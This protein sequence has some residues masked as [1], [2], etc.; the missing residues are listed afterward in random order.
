MRYVALLWGPVRD[1]RADVSA[2]TEAGGTM[3][4]AAATTGP[5]MIHFLTKLDVSITDEDDYGRSPLH[6]P[7]MSNSPK[8]VMALL[9]LGADPANWNCKQV[10][11]L[12]EAVLTRKASLV[13][14]CLSKYKGSWN[15]LD[16]FGMSVFDYINLLP[17][18]IAAQL[19]FTAIDMFNDKQQ[20]RENEDSVYSN[21]CD[22][23]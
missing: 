8:V 13:T 7:C 22:R 20:S 21:V 17:S 12:I 6:L 16:G 23:D 14:P 18:H 5:E 19:G 3:L 15:A 11:P 10:T 1:N 9:D 4:H 2:K